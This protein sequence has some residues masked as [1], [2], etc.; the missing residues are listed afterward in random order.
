M[1]V[2]TEDS[3]VRRALIGSVSDSVIRHA[4]CPVLEVRPEKAQA[5]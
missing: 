5:P 4:Q 2:G 1:G 3:G